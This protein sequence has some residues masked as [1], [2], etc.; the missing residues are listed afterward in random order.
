MLQSVA[1]CRAQECDSTAKSKEQ[2]NFRHIIHMRHKVCGN[3]K[4]PKTAATLGRLHVA[5]GEEEEMGGTDDEAG[6]LSVSEELPFQ[7]HNCSL[8]AVANANKH[9]IMRGCC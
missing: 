6:L 8:S 7:R 5:A 4:W 3:Q 1:K 2:A 9:G